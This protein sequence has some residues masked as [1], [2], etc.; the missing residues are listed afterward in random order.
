MGEIYTETVFWM[1]AMVFVW[2]IFTLALFIV[3]PI[4]KK[5]HRQNN[6]GSK[7]TM[8]VTLRLHVI[9]LMVS[10]V[11]VFISVLGAHGIL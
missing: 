8:E 10:L 4:L 2:L 5:R 6:Q 7:H 11:T 1:H 9:L 3:E